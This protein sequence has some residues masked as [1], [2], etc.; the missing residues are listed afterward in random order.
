MK[1]LELFSGTHS[2]GKVAH[3]RGF[4]VVSVDR[5]IGAE[6]PLGSGYK[7]DLHIQKDIMTWVYKKDFKEGE[8]DLIT[9]S[10]VCLWWSNCRNVWIGKKIKAHGDEI[11]TQDILNEDIEK[12]G[13][14]MIDK[15]FEIIDYFKPKY[16]WIENPKSGKMK[17]YINDLIPFYD[18]DYC[19][20]GLKYKK[21]TRFWTNIKNF[22]YNKC[23]HK[24]HLITIG[25]DHKKGKTIGGGSNRLERYRIPEKLI[26]ELLIHIE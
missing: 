14:P 7:S 3:K 11:I 10:P 21:S 13:V 2:I 20:F 17:E 19:M 26:E 24:K 15:V 25:G 9:A 4:E 1:V 23:N 16:W 5:D 8:F 6:C 22:K 18:V 12:F